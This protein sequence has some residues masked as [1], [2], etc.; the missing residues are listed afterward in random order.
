[1]AQEALARAYARW[2]RVAALPRALGGPGGHQPRPG[3]LAEGPVGPAG[4]GWR[5]TVDARRHRPAHG[6]G[7]RCCGACPAASGRWWSCAT[8]PT[9]PSRRPPT[10]SA[11]P[12]ARSSSTP[13]AASPRSDPRS[14]T[15][16]EGCD[17]RTTRP[18]GGVPSRRG[19]PV[20]RRDPGP[21]AAPASPPDRRRRPRDGRRDGGGRRCRPRAGRGSSGRTSSGSRC[22]SSPRPSTPSTGSRSTCS[23][24]ASTG[25]GPMASS[26]AAGRH[27][28]GR[29]DRRPTRRRVQVVSIPR[30]LW[31]PIPRSRGGTHQ[32][33][34][35]RSA[36]RPPLVGTVESALGIPIDRYLQVD[37]DGFRELVDAAGGV[38]RR[39]RRTRAVGEHRPERADPGLPALRRHARPRARCG[40]AT[41]CSG[42]STARWRDDAYR[43]LRADDPPADVRP[44]ASSTRLGDARSDPVER[45][46][47]LD[48]FARPRHD[49]HRTGPVSSSRA[50]WT[51]RPSSG[52]TTSAPASCPVAR[53]R[54]G[55]RPGAAARGRGAGRCDRGPAGRGARSPSRARRRA[56]QPDVP[57]FGPC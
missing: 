3:P 50:S 2:S 47:L 19:V 33:R 32:Q 6:P 46:R 22:S 31:V 11:A 17:V 37:F 48:V 21:P 55:R 43:R 40:P 24:S 28:H 5:S 45:G 57:T 49:G 35:A 41:T 25:P 4:S 30:D 39:V 27:D 51:S 13:T 9:G 52:P 8:W 53:R 42:S 15:R 10:R 29:A 54:A 12:P 56:S 36:G 38:R 7:R 1:M 18:T 16:P 26:R 23:W 44:G 20:R 34:A 14:S